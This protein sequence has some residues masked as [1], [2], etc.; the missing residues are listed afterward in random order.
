MVD[1]LGN[2]GALEGAE[3]QILTTSYLSEDAIGQASSDDEIPDVLRSMPTE[4][5]RSTRRRLRSLHSPRL[6]QDFS[7]CQ[8]SCE[9]CHCLT[10][11]QPHTRADIAGKLPCQ[12]A[13]QSDDEIPNSPPP[14]TDSRK[15]PT[16]TV[17]LKF[18]VLP[19][20]A[21][22]TKSSKTSLQQPPKRGVLKQSLK[23]MKFR[24][25]YINDSG[26]GKP[27]YSERALQEAGIDPKLWRRFLHMSRHPMIFETGNG[28]AKAILSLALTSQLFW[29]H[30]N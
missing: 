20:K 28:M 7:S 12:P 14:V 8:T 5:M 1:P 15:S 6:V 17:S 26:A 27:V 29:P 18:R 25:E 16:H 11:Y 10:T 2:F 30:L 21:N 24:V 4:G 19:S 13:C 22:P 3:Q 23:P 9:G